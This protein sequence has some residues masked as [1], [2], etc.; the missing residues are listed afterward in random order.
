MEKHTWRGSLLLAVLLLVAVGLPVLSA[1]D[2]PSSSWDSAAALLEAVEASGAQVSEV[3][4]RATIDGDHLP[5]AEYLRAKANEW[6]SLL[7]L[8]VPQDPQQDKGTYI[9]Q[10]LG[11]FGEAKLHV[12]FVGVPQNSGFRTYLVVKM[13]GERSALKDLEQLYQQVTE[14]LAEKSAIPHF[15]TCVRGIYSDTLS[16]DQ[17]EGKVFAVLQYLRAQPVERLHDE[18]VLSLSAYAGQWQHWIKTG[19]HKMNLQVA[20]HTDTMGEITRITAGTPIITAEY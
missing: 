9:M 8:S 4:L 6:N 2:Q 15:S 16:D 13:T 10:T 5:D 14:R 17:Q 20:T 3:E 18:T 1:D 12:R 7:G 19:Q 11:V